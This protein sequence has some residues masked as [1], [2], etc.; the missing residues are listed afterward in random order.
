MGEIFFL[1]DVFLHRL[2]CD[3]FKYKQRVVFVIFVTSGNEQDGYYQTCTF[4]H[5]TTMK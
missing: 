1:C 3:A 5:S 2:D 4:A